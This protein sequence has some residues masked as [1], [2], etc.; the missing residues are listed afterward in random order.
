MTNNA[1]R[2]DRRRW[3]QT[4]AALAALGCTAC[5]SVGQGGASS[6]GAGTGTGLAEDLGERLEQGVQSG[7]LA[8]LHAVAVMRHGRLALER[9]FQGEDERWGEPLGKVAFNADSLHDVRSVSKSIVGLL[10]GM[11]LAE[12][13]VPALDT[14]LVQA[15]PAYGDLAA[16]E[17]RRAIL[18][19]HALGMTMG[20]QWDEDLPYSDPRNSEIAMERSS[21][22]YRYVLEQP[23]VAPPGER[24][25]YSGG[26]TALLGHLIAQGSG[27]PLLDYA[28]HKLFAPLGIDKAEWTPGT[29]GEAAAASGL[30]L[31][32]RDLARIGQLVLQQGEWP[33]GRQGRALVPRHWIVQSIQP[34]VDAWPGLRYGHHWYVGQTRAGLAYYMAIGLGGQR[35]VVVPQ[36]SLVYAVFMGNYDSPQ[37]VQRVGAVQGLIAAALR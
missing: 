21:D 17:G 14:P 18:V 10:Y 9:Y 30:R 27:M 35:L 34:R 8:N 36:H 33:G 25:C 28:R 19:S 5:A 15:F 22:R 26:A 32:A 11:A 31:R 7:E 29:N 16:D 37:Q 13:K 6:T 23:I 24:W 20:L 4:G 12:G 2:T 1:F 3:L